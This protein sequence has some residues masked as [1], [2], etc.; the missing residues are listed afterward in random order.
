MKTAYESMDI[1]QL[2]AE[3]DELIQQIDSEVIEDMEEEQR[4][5]L[6][7]HIQSLNKLKSE[8]QEKVEKEG[9]SEKTTYSEGTHEAIESIVKAMKGLARYLS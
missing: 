8:V 4:A 1:D 3:A 9:T 2:L 7:E 6:E 5:Q